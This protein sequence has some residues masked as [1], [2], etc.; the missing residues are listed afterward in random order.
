MNM[1]PKLMMAFVDAKSQL[2]LPV[3]TVPARI[4]TGRTIGIPKLATVMIL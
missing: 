3:Q 2:A 1:P 4:I